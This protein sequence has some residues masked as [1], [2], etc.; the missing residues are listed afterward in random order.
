MDPARPARANRESIVSEI[1][2]SF[3]SCIFNIILTSRHTILD[4]FFPSFTLFKM[5]Q[6]TVFRA[7][8][9]AAR[10]VQRIQPAFAPI[11]QQIGT[12][13]APAI[14]WYSDAPAADAKAKEGEAAGAKPEA[15]NEATQLK[16]QMEKKDREIIDLKV[17]CAMRPI[18]Q[19]YFTT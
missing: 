6:R 18:S 4:L 19:T 10:P 2:L 16:E 11:R 17:S 7:S 15:S 9:Q 14:R 8:R 5:L 13:A 12:R 1:F 3:E